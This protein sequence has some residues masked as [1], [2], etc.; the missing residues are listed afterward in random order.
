MLVWR[1]YLSTSASASA[2]AGQKSP[3]LLRCAQLLDASRAAAA[4]DGS[5]S[6]LDNRQIRV[7]G[8]IRSVRK[9]KRIAFAE[10][11]DGSTIKTVQAILTPGQ[12][13]GYVRPDGFFFTFL[14]FF[15][16]SFLHRARCVMR[17]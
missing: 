16:S 1:R 5:S 9:Q 11:S 13:A 12:A 14:P 4:A 15:H 3:L 2:I 8:F 7:Q 10:I 17:F 6:S